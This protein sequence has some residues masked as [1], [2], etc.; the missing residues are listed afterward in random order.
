M[1]IYI[2]IPKKI[3]KTTKNLLRILLD[4]NNITG[5]GIVATY[6]NIKCTEI[7][8]YTSKNRSFK[9]IYYLCKTYFPNI[10]KKRVLMELCCLYLP[11]FKV[12]IKTCNTIDDCRFV[13]QKIENINKNDDLLFS[14]Y[15]S[16]QR[17]RNLIEECFNIDASNMSI[18]ELNSFLE[19]EVNK[20]KKQQN[21]V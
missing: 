7:Q 19:T 1:K 11:Q 15:W 8:C 14:R 5:Q 21:Y 12:N 2:T 4:P 10:T 6:K 20:F 13:Y 3:F 9:D 16:L 17:Q 18:E